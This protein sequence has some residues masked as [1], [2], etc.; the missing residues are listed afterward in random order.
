MFETEL[1]QSNLGGAGP[2]FGFEG[3]RFEDA[4]IHEGQPFDMVVTA[5]GTYTPKKSTDNGFECGQPTT[6]CTT[7]H[8]AQISVAAGT[9]V[10]LTIEFQDSGTQKPVTLS[11]FMFSLHDIDRLSS[12]VEEIIY[13]SGFTDAVI[14]DAATE[15]VSTLEPDGRTKLTSGQD[16]TACDDPQNPVRLS[17]VTCSGVAIDQKKRSAAFL[18]KDTSSIALSLEV[19][20]NNCSANSGR[21]FLFAGETN[22]VSCAS[23]H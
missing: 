21:S 2:D 13:I 15:I 6:G 10:D 12:K 4:G 3:M 22:L 1:V 5:T 18:F 14:L 9:H 19:T 11:S 23:K 20:C 17:S 16:G 7:G 8:F